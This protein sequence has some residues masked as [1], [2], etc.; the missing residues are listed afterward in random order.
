M[1]ARPRRAA[2]ISVSAGPVVSVAKMEHLV[3]DLSN[4]GERVEL[5]ALHL[6]EQPAQLGI[7]RDSAFEMHLRARRPNC[8]HL[9]GEMLA[10]ALLQDS[11][12]HEESTVRFDV[13]PELRHVLPACRVGQD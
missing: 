5:S 9:G 1:L 13:L 12:V 6:V 2:S 8:E 4:R 10:A 3:N 11:L 7:P